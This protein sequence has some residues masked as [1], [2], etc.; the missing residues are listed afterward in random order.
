MTVA[1]HATLTPTRGCVSPSNAASR[2]RCCSARCE[3]DG[4]GARQP[5]V[6]AAGA[7][8]HREVAVLHGPR[9]RGGV[10]D[11]EGAVVERHRDRRAGAR[12]DV[13]LAEALELLGRLAGRR[14]EAEVQ[15]RRRG[16]VARARVGD[17]DRDARRRRLE[18]RVRERRVAQ[19]VAEGEGGREVLGVVVAVADLKVLRVGGDEVDARPLRRREGLL[20]LERREGQREAARRLLVAEDDV[21]D[22]VA[23]LLAGHECGDDG[24]DVVAPRRHDRAGLHHRHDGAL[25]RLGHG[26][27]QHVGLAVVGRQ[28][29]RGAV[30][31]LARRR[32]REHD[33]HVG[34]GRDRRSL[35][36]VRAVSVV[37]AALRR[38]RA[39]VGGGRGRRDAHD[40][41]HGRAVLDRV[42][43][44][45][46]HPAGAADERERIARLAAAARRAQVT[47]VH[48]GARGR[49]RLRV[50]VAVVDAGRP[51]RL[52]AVARAGRRRHDAE[53]RAERV[54]RRS[55]I[56]RHH[57]ATAAAV[58]DRVRGLVADDG[59]AGHRVVERQ[60]LVDV[61]EQHHRAR[62]QLARQRVVRGAGDVG[63]QRPRVVVVEHAHLEHGREDAQRR[64][65][66]GRLRDGTALHRRQQR[67]AHKVGARHLLV[68]A[69]RD[70]RRVR[71]APIAH[72]PAAEVQALLQVARQVVRVLARP[73]AVD[74]VVGAH[75]RA[76][77]GVD[78]ALK[79][80]VVQLKLLALAHDLGH[81]VAVRLLAVVDPVLGV[82]DDALAL[83][84]RDDRRH[85]RRTQERVLTADVLEVATALGDPREAQARSELHVGALAIEL[86]AHGRAPL[87][88]GVDVERR[89][90]GEAARPRR[91]G[92][93][94]AAEALRAVVELKR[95]DPEARVGLDVADVAA[96]AAVQHVH[97]LCEVHRGQ[98][99][100][101]SRR[102]RVRRVHP[103]C[104][105][106]RFRRR[107]RDSRR[108]HC[109]Q[110]HQRRARRHG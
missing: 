70:R 79:G 9:V 109:H 15:L 92:A 16:A 62:G 65:I 63:L 100:L 102:G 7:D 14:G 8:H 11:G 61:L 41:R 50:L 39:A 69:G 106:P 78:G 93:G 84:A 36:H 26:L 40:A 108:S 13:H 54:E 105:R 76:D 35:V 104:R 99:L 96:S 1:L 43:R 34:H 83:D 90:D 59:D 77:A 57:L 28:V 48:R 98:Q 19:A 52:R 10:P 24:V 18:A 44:V 75:H 31:A 29:Q 87:A 27:D 60:R 53:A 6:A 74:L 17:G 22:G 88:G 56:V 89:A 46:L 25:R 86:D 82:G 73:R 2:R 67:V 101:R 51:V 12:L 20:A 66:H 5:D 68:E 71:R 30:A 3:S 38:A 81:G 107:H 97:L 58:H 32:R 110:R 94:D 47:A 42:V 103:R 64:V 72:H 95:G 49:R 55:H 45:A 91:A 23:V 80:G 4:E 33:R 85:H 37:D 21:H